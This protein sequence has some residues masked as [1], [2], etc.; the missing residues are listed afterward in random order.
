MLLNYITE[1]CHKKQ[2]AIINIGNGDRKFST[3]P[4]VNVSLALK[5]FLEQ[6]PLA[7][8]LAE[9]K[10]F[11][12]TDG[13]FCRA[14]SFESF[15]QKSHANFT[16]IFSTQCPFQLLGIIRYS[17]IE[18]EIKIHEITI[19]L[20]QRR[21]GFGKLLVLYT[22]NHVN[23]MGFKKISLLN[24][25]SYTPDIINL[26]DTLTVPPLDK[27]DFKFEISDY[28]Y[29]LNTQQK[30]SGSFY[31]KLGFQGET[32]MRLKLPGSP[33]I[34]QELFKSYTPLRRTQSEPNLAQIQ[35]IK[36]S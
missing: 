20:T 8:I 17:H 13:G 12:E 6:K 23:I 22:I 32:F 11:M 24:V 21:N 7:I 9:V 25:P 3:G 35:P 29:N 34:Y 15:L 4:S 16:C 36:F 10:Q 14:F 19:T 2:I 27:Y 1:Q 18:H 28:L 31:E 26:L 33:Q 5:D 30:N